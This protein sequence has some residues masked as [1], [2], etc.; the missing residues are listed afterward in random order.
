MVWTAEYGGGFRETAAYLEV[1]TEPAAAKHAAS[2][3]AWE[4]AAT[5]GWAELWSAWCVSAVARRGIFF[6]FR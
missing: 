6:R 2:K 5:H 4:T 1:L 3:H